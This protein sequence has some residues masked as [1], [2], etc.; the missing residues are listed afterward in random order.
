MMNKILSVS[1]YI[2]A[3]ARTACNVLRFLTRNTIKGRI[4]PEM[5]KYGTEAI[6]ASVRSLVAVTQAVQAAGED[7][8]QFQDAG[9]LIR[10]QDLMNKVGD[11]LDN[12]NKIG[13]EAA[14]LDFMEIMNLAGSLVPLL[15]GLVPRSK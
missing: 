11:L 13:P 12:V 3:V 14:D 9:L 8:W 1:L 4:D 6:Q 10:N 5:P 2:V 15:G 7:G